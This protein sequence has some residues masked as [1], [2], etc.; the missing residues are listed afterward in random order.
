V[1]I[2]HAGYGFRPWRHGGLIAYAEDVMDGQAARGHEVGYFFRGRHYPGLPDDRL[3]RWRR[4]GVAM[5]EILNSS[6]AFG[7]DSGTLTPGAD[8]H[9]PPSEYHFARV[10]DELRPEVIHLQE[11][12][13]LPTSVIDVARDRGVPI[14]AT[15]Q[16]Y[17]PLCPVLKL[18]D[19]DGRICLRHDVGAQCARCSA[20]APADRRP[21][22]HMTLEYELGRLLGE[23]RARPAMGRFKAAAGIVR[24]VRGTRPPA[25]RAEEPPRERAAAAADYQARREVNVERLSRLDAVV[26]QSRRVGEIYTQL[27]VEPTRVRVLQLTLAHLERMTPRRIAESPRPVRFATL[28]GGA[29]VEKGAELLV[30]ALGRL[31]DLTH[32][33]TLSVLGYVPPETAALLRRFGNVEVRGLYPPGAVDHVLD[34]FDVGIVPSI[35]EEAYGY[36]GPEFLAKGIPVIGNARGGIV[37]YVRDGE[38]GWVN[39]SADAVGLAAL[40]ERVVGNPG[41]IVERNRW[42]LEHRAEVIKPLGRHLDELDELY[43]QIAAVRLP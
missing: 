40:I 30:D 43:R 1:R 41:E 23:R 18:Y 26:A 14:M 39:A 21:F 16:D 12:I 32:R 24:R 42:L 11:A 29:S 31:D 37:D 38:T 5:R 34:D 6:L 8:L 28:N 33:F 19:V 15:L 20:W 35:W 9:H 2:L 13:G 10:L 4:R 22:A 25:D 27:G 7:G 3:R 36:V 17:L